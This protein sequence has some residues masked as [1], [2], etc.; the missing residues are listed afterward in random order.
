MKV[1]HA[2]L[3]WLELHYESSRLPIIKPKGTLLA[4]QAEE[5]FEYLTSVMFGL[6]PH[7]CELEGRNS[8]KR[9]KY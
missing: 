6:G 3:S 5:S 9:I 7:S 4:A 2:E 8:E 1:R